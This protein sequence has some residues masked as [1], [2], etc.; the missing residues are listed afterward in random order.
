MKHWCLFDVLWVT[1]W[2]NEDSIFHSMENN[3]QLYVLYKIQITLIL[4]NKIQIDI[5]KAP[6][7]K[8]VKVIR[9]KKN[10]YTVFSII[11]KK[12]HRILYFIFYILYNIFYTIF[13]PNIWLQKN[14]NASRAPAIKEAIFINWKYYGK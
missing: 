13:S 12:Y 5:E 10:L 14:W 6:F 2:F 9:S 1:R 8:K 7:Y 11:F 3:T 4:F